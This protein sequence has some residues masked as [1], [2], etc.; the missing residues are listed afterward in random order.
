M[1]ATAYRRAIVACGLAAIVS[2]SMVAFRSAAAADRELVPLASGSYD[3]RFAGVG[4]EGR[5]MVWSGPATGPATGEMTIRL[6][7]EGAELDMSQP[8]WVVEGIVIVSGEPEDSFAAE[9]EGIIDW[10]QG[11]MRLH[12]VVSVGPMKGAEF[13]Q[14]ARITDLDLAGE[15]RTARAVASR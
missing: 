6:A 10:K 9:V 12:G 8:A 7:Y 15:W 2:I 14:T 5:D 1:R 4:A 13:E 3:T 11:K